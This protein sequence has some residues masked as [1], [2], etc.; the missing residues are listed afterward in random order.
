MSI[1]PLRIYIYDEGLVRLATVKYEKAV[2]GAKE[3]QYKHLTNYSL[4]KHNAAFQENSNALCDDEGSKQSISA[5]RR[6]LKAMGHDAD[7]IFSHIEDV[8]I[9]TI[10]SVEHVINNAVDMFVPY[11]NTNCFE[12]FGF[13]ILIDQDLKAWLLEVN[14]TPALSCDSPLD[15]KVKSN[16]IAD[17]LSM[18][19]IVKME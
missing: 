1:H 12:L 13:D 17:L 6:K 10:I 16:C 14:L 5:F 2:G 7:K 11:K 3:N 18:A 8:I 19:G 15:Q 9:K 4:N